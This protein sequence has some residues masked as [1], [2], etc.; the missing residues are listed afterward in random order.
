MICDMKLTQKSKLKQHIE[1][2]IPNK[3]GGDIFVG[4]L[5]VYHEVAWQH[6]MIKTLDYL[7]YY[8]TGPLQNLLE[9][10]NHSHQDLAMILMNDFEW[11][12]FE[13]Y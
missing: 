12:W 3:V 2:I 4:F 1:I 5:S 8:P 13:W 11:S 7:G 10:S 6:P 9:Y